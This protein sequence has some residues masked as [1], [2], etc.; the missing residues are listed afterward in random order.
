MLLCKVMHFPTNPDQSWHM[1]FSSQEKKYWRVFMSKNQPLGQ[2]DEEVGLM[3]YHIFSDGSEPN[4]G[5][6][7]SI[8]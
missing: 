6:I 2:M 3:Q 1:Y 4:L 7:F 5:H 8:P